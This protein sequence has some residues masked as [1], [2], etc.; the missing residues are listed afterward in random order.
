LANVGT[1]NFDLPDEIQPLRARGGR[2]RAV[3]RTEDAGFIAMHRRLGSAVCRTA[4]FGAT[5]LV[6]MLCAA[7]GADAF[8]YWANNNGTIGRAKLTGKAANQSFI[9]GI[10]G[11]CGVAVDRAHIYWTDDAS[12][13]IGRAKLNGKGI[14]RNFITGG[15]N[16]CGVAVDGSHVYWANTDLGGSIGRAKLN[17]E[18]VDQNFVTGMDDPCGVAVDPKNIYWGNRDTNAIGRADLKGK[19]IN[20]SFIKTVGGPCGVAVDSAHIYWANTFPPGTTI[21]RANLKGKAV[22]QSFITGA[23]G[24]PCGPA[25]DDAHVYWGDSLGTTISRARLSGKGAHLS[26]IVGADHPCFVAVDLPLARRMSIAY[27][28]NS[29]KGK[30]SSSRSL[31]AKGQNVRVYRRKPGPDP[32]V[33]AH[34]TNGRGR[35]SIRKSNAKGSFYAKAHRSV[36]SSSI[37][38][39]A[40]RSRPLKVG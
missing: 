6:V 40:A 29:F 23:G 16:P 24:R 4:G 20:Q 9:S 11:A 1:T 17:G 15:N 34:T 13:R 14:N 7:Q 30:L 39:L 26:F 38:C 5:L 36:A 32:L 33:G 2:G 8:V 35:Y 18:G 10:N 12:G 22:D 19:G 25:V 28:H 27:T 3:R 21:G 37:V 31:C